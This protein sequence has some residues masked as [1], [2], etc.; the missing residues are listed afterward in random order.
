M[1]EWRGHKKIPAQCLNCDTVKSCFGGCR[2]TAETITKDCKGL[3]PWMTSQ[4]TKTNQQQQTIMPKLK[5]QTKIISSDIFRWRKEG[6][7]AFLV[8][9]RRG[10]R[11]IT[12]INEEYFHFLTELRECPDISLDSLATKFGTNFEDTNYQRIITEITSKGFATLQQ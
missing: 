3:D 10:N 2:I 6:E 8:T 7:D 5:P 9:S 4:I 12:M 1:E 11:N